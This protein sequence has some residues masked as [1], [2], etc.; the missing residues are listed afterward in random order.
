MKFCK[1]LQRV[2]EISDPEWAPYWPNYKMLKKLIK[3]LPSLVPTDESMKHPKDVFCCTLGTNIKHEM[4][5]NLSE[6]TKKSDCVV[7]HNEM[8]RNNE[9]NDKDEQESKSI[10]DDLSIREQ[11]NSPQKNTKSTVSRSEIISNDVKAMKKSPG[12]I[13]FFKLLNSE[14][15]KACIFFQTAEQEFSLREERIREGKT[16]MEKSNSIMVSNRWSLLAKSLYRLYK[17]LLLLE[18][19]A[20]MT[21]CSF[22]KILKKHDKISGFGTRN[23]FMANVVSKANFSSYPKLLAMI[24]RTEAFHEEVSAHLVD[25][26]KDSLH[27]DERLF[28][29]MIHRLNQQ[30]LQ[31]EWEVPD[32]VD[33]KVGLGDHKSSKCTPESRIFALKSIVEEND[34]KVASKRIDNIDS[35]TEHTNHY[36]HLNYENKKRSATTSDTA[37]KK[38]RPNIMKKKCTQP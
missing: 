33:R 23:A 13:A 38:Q 36:V 22:S 24:S 25:K 30:T 7:E 21:Y 16:I 26:G 4:K 17:D 29:N 8:K 5:S 28:I 19:F 34:S 14:L 35:K 9:K 18:T 37:R 6:K 2:V 27:E 15:K 31:G 1:N 10:C 11:I 32:V 20:I 12:E 3:E